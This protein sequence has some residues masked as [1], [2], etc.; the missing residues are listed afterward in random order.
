[1]SYRLSK[2]R[3]L[4]EPFCTGRNKYIIEAFNFIENIIPEG[5]F[6]N[7][8]IKETTVVSKTNNNLIQYSCAEPG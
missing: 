5:Y 6:E 7:G 3:P 8:M 4:N 2:N 1:M